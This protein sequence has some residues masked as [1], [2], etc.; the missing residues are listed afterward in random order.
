MLNAKKVSTKV[1]AI[2]A[3]FATAGASATITGCISVVA[4]SSPLPT[5]LRPST[6]GAA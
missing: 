6:G 4:P 2:A 1:A 5:K 3:F